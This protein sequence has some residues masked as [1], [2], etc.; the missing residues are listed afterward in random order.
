LQLRA[1]LHSIAK[2][3]DLYNRR[4]LSVDVKHNFGPGRV[5][6]F[7][8][9]FNQVSAEYLG[10]PD[11]AKTPNAPVSYPC[12]WDAPQHD[13]V[14]WNGAAENRTSVLG[15]P[16]FGTDQVGALGRNAGEVLGVFGWVEINDFELLLPRKYDS[17]VVK[18]NLISIEKSLATLWSPEW[19]FPPI[20]NEVEIRKR[21]EAVYRNNCI[22]CH[23][24][25]DRKDPKRKIVAHLEN[26]GTDPMMIKNFARTG[27]TGRLEGRRKTILGSERFQSEEPVGV[28]LKHVVERTILNSLSLA[29]MKK[30]IDSAKIADVDS[31]NPGYKNTAIVKVG[32][33]EFRVPLDELIE[34]AESVELI[35]SA[36]KLLSF[37]EGLRGND[38]SPKLAGLG[39]V[40]KNLLAV[41]SPTE[42]APAT[43]VL[44]GATA[45]FG[46][47]ARPL[48]GIWATAPYLH[49][50]SVPNLTELL[51][52][53]SNRK[54]QFHVGS[55][56]YDTKNVGFVD[57]QSFPVFDTSV[58]GN[59]NTG[60]EFGANLTQQ[61]KLDLIEYLKSL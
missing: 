39:A 38:S 58:E 3:R 23:A 25:I 49:N 30:T 11:N 42:N 36:S 55:T 34:K 6:A 1:F 44:P 33:R 26:V 32:G 51:K 5:D 40:P 9:I 12:L 54:K 15:V 37:A 28:I 14:Q 16:L 60:H 59:S 24:V 19:P 13:R 57:D 52:P 50:G 29:Q 18:E 46:Y 2:E 45:S 35:S 7:G 56:A 53:H 31:L 10:I 43:A 20:E 41:R 48:N 17:T 22:Q 47:K 27:N 61:Q 4:N 21:G 8:A